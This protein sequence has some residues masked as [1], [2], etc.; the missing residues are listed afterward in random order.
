[1]TEVRDRAP[2]PGGSEPT[3][4]RPT[5]AGAPP[6]PSA[7]RL[8]S[9]T[10]LRFFAAFA[11]FVTH[12]VG[13]GAGGYGR[14]P[15]I[16]PQSTYGTHGVAFFFV[17]S[18]FVLT[19]M[20]K[21]GQPAGRFY[22]RRVARIV[23]LHLATSIVAIWV[24]Y[25]PIS[26]QTF[27]LGPYLTS[28]FL[29]QAWI[30]H[31]S[32]M[33]PGNGVSWTLSCEAFFYLCFPLIVAVLAPL[34]RRRLV[35]VVGMVVVAA[36]AWRVYADLTLTPSMSSWSLRTPIFRIWEF[37][38]GIVLALLLRRGTVLKGSTLTVAL[39]LGAWI[40]VYF[41]LRPHLP[42]AWADSVVYL[43]QVVAPLLFAWV[44]GVAAKRDLSGRRSWLASKPMVL[45]GAWSFAFYLVHYF[46]LRLATMA[47]GAREASNANMF[48]LIGMG[49]VA[50]ALAA[51]CYYLIEHPAERRLRNLFH[52]TPARSVRD[53]SQIDLAADEAA[54]RLR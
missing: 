40:L 17:L 34:R 46:P 44:L 52:R 23:P 20:W 27:E 26:N 29:V 2:R 25:E 37:V 6:L 43:D 14:V 15:A 39:L 51:I 21:P 12:F 38:L 1:M 54:T 33:F 42:T 45:L 28:I 18:G 31:L 47:F 10:G 5:R 48:D 36:L 35:L 11:V 16:Y 53:E 41:N 32:P 49:V 19:W 50:T 7:T 22:W 4:A 8:D 24:Y 30:P 3:L 13:S 9:L